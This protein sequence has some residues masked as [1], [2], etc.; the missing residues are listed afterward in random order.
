MRPNNEQKNNEVSSEEEKFIT[1][2]S[3]LKKNKLE[4]SKCIRKIKYCFYF[5][6]LSFLAGKNE[7]KMSFE[8]NTNYVRLLRVELTKRKKRASKSDRL[9]LHFMLI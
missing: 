5:V 6:L 2:Y 7:M 4:V 9:P 3:A 1:C 8:S